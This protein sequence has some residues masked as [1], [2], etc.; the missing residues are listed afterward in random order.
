MTIDDLVFCGLNGYVA[1]ISRENGE[2]VWSNDELESGC[3]SLLLDGD[4]LVVSANGYL[5]CLDPLTGKMLWKNPLTGYGTGVASIVSAR[6]QSFP[7]VSLQASEQDGAAI[8]FA[9]AAT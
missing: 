2:I 6:G 7:T 3:V 8:V 4:R 9:A 1:A 5:Y